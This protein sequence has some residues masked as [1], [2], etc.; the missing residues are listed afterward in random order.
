MPETPMMEQYW[1]IKKRYPD[2]LL[3]FRLGD[4]YEMFFADA[5]TAAAELGLTLTSREAGKG[6][7]VPMCGV[8]YHAAEGYIARLIQ[9]G[10]NVAICEQVEDPRL[11]KGLVERQVIRVVTPGTFLDDN[12]LDKKQNNYLVAITCDAAVWGLAVVDAGTGELKV[13]EVRAEEE[14]QFME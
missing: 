11:A 1:E 4:F 9:N 10:H 12:V 2:A 14:E 5:E 6:H 7:R 3:F 8:P 13:T